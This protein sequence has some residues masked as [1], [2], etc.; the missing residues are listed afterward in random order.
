MT[1]PLHEV[2]DAMVDALADLPEGGEFG[3]NG[4][5]AAAATCLRI[6]RSSRSRTHGL[7]CAQ[8][9]EA[10]KAAHAEGR[11]LGRNRSDNPT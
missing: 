3:A 5:A 10:A 8:L 1:W 7:S 9:L 6:L 11:H 2:F 4:S